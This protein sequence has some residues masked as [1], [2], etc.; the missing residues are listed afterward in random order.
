MEN[1]R[2]VSWSK[3]KGI[4][5]IIIDNPSVNVLSYAVIEQLTA[6]VDEIERD[7][8]V[9]AVLLTGAGEKAFVAGGDIKSFPEWIGKGSEYAEEKSL[10]LQNPLN[11]IERLPKPTIAAI[12]GLA[13]GGGCELALSCDL[14]IIEEHAQIGLPEVKLGLFPGAGGTQRLPRLI[15]AASAKEMMFTGEP[16]TAEEAWRVGL[17][18]HVVPRGEALNKAKELAAK[19]ARFSL[20]ALSLMKQSI[21]KGLSFSLEEGLKIEAENFGRV[22]QTSDVK[23]GVE[24]FIEKRVPLFHHK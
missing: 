1:K 4:A 19:M 12:N 24:A 5:T 15:G 17:V 20:P 22:F 11:K 3:E 14:R 8:E 21:N 2:V 6:A 7:D 10:W 23:E 16:L 18:N 9:I 13:L